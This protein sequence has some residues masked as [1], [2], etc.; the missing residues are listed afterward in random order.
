MLN[1]L[2]IKQKEF[3]EFILSKYVESG[4]EEL[5][6]E[7]LPDLLKI[8]YH[9]YKD[10]KNFLGDVKEIRDTFISFQGYLYTKN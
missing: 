9:S 4:F 8:K 3:L 2:D 5:N 1:N 6:E 10:A 7:K